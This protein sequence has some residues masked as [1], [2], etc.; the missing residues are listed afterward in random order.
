VEFIAPGKALAGTGWWQAHKPHTAIL[1]KSL[2]DKLSYR[3]RSKRKNILDA[4]RF[5]EFGKCKTSV[6]Y[7][8][9]RD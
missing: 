7:H 9:F 3:K 4:D 5:P 6:E 2:S 8:E 1:A